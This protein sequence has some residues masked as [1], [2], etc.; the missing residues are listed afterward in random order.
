MNVCHLISF[1]NT[2]FVYVVD[3]PQANY[4]AT[5][6]SSYMYALELDSRSW[7]S[8]LI[9][10]ANIS[11]LISSCFQAVI[12]SKYHSFLK[13]HV[14]LSFYRAPLIVS[15][16]FSIVGNTLYSY[17]AVHA[18]FNMALLGRFLFGFGSS[19]LLNRQLLNAALPIDSI[20]VE[21]AVRLEFA[22]DFYPL[23]FP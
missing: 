5:I 22:N 19:E 18:S 16:I 2:M 11:S 20:N 4:Y 10:V 23:A 14:N 3:F 1:M 12:L 7:H 8:L 21:V 6:P 9:G 17:A 15:A 13:R